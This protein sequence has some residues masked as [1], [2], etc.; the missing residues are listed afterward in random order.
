MKIVRRIFL[1]LLLAALPAWGVDGIAFITNLKGEVAVDGSSRPVLLSE[2]AKGQRISVGKDSQ[3][4]VMYIASGKEYVLKGPNEFLVKD[5]EISSSAGMPPVTRETQWRASNKVLM[6]V[7]QTS[8]A[9][10]RMRSIS[11]PRADTAPKLLFPTDGSV[12]T[13]Q[14]TFRWR[15]AD[16][17]ATGDF[18]LLIIGQEKP[19]HTAKAAGDSYRVPARLK[20]ETEYAWT[21][22]S[23]GSEVGSGRFRTLS[24]DALTR[25]EKRRPGEKA[26]FSDRLLFTLM[27]HEMGATQEARES[28]AR[29]A[30]ERADLPELSALAR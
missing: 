21:V 22:T 5:I 26:E 8:A 10:V 4:S 23:A 3:A 19:V 12:A 27:L 18:T 16:A 6:Q 24:S 15:A 2:L 20:P 9:S 13:L 30:Q 25:V 14:P 11:R 29:L 7:A 28:W 17:K 1:V